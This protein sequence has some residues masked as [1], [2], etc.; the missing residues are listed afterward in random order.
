MSGVCQN[1]AIVLICG[2]VPILSLRC[3]S[4]ARRHAQKHLFSPH[5]LSLY[6]LT[7]FQQ[8]AMVLLTGFLPRLL[9]ARRADRTARPGQ[10][11]PAK[12]RFVVS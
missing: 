11:F 8:L 3:L 1:P 2:S 4:L 12:C 7:R 6:W 10:E 9:M 5:A